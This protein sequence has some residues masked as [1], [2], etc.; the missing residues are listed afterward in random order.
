MTDSH[1]SDGG[2]RPPALLSMFINS[3]DTLRQRA[4]DQTMSSEWNDKPPLFTQYKPMRPRFWQAPVDTQVSE[5]E[6]PT[7]LKGVSM[8]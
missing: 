7:L 5:Q 6:D 8:I 4:I 1:R 2:D 3:T